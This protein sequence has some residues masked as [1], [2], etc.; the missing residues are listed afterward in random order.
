MSNFGAA[1]ESKGFADE[2]LDVGASV[3]GGEPNSNSL[4]GT[5]RAATPEVFPAGEPNET[6][7]SAEKISEVAVTGAGPRAL[8][9]LKTLKSVAAMGICGADIGLVRFAGA[10]A[11]SDEK[12][13][14]GLNQSVD[15]VAGALVFCGE[16]EISGFQAVT[17]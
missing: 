6:V 7:D 3:C 17:I 4:E 11:L 14:I 12:D 8:A 5:A 2:T 1:H 9:A 15:T 16:E 10:E 13:T